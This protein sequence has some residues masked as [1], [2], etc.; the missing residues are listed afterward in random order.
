MLTL[1]NYLVLNE[2]DQICNVKSSCFSPAWH[3]FRN[4]RFSFIFLDLAVL[5]VSLTEHSMKEVEKAFQDTARK[6]NLSESPPM[7]NLQSVPKVKDYLK[8]N[9]LRFCALVIDADRIESGHE[10]QP[11]E[12]R[13]YQQLLET[14]VNHVGKIRQLLLRSVIQSRQTRAILCTNRVS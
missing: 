14:V 9:R 12:S 6:L 3:K 13:G 7:I 1:F 8:E 11:E 10:H 2:Y 4:W 5:G